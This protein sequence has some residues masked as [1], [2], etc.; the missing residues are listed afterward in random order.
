MPLHFQV[1]EQDV[2]EIEE[3]LKS[4]EVQVNGK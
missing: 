2:F 4:G 3:S 1:R